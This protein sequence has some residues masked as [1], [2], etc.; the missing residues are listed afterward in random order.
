MSSHSELELPYT[1]LTAN[2]IIFVCYIQYMVMFNTCVKKIQESI[3]FHRKDDLLHKIQLRVII[4]MS[5]IG[6]P[7]AN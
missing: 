6:F 4:K 3:P 7:H 5:I 2:Y 1:I